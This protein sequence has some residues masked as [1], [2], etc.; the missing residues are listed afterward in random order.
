MK[1]L[2]YI[3]S[4]FI[5][6]ILSIGLVGCGSKTPTTVVENYLDEV[7]KGEDG[8]ASHL[9]KTV[10]EDFE[11][12][13]SDDVEE[14]LSSEFNDELNKIMKK[15]EY[16]VNSETVDGDTAIVNVTV[17]GGNISNALVQAITSA[18]GRT[19]ELAFSGNEISDEESEKIINEEFLNALKN[20]EFDERTCDISLVKEDKEW[21][22]EEDDSLKIL[23]LGEGDIE[24]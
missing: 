9:L 5:I 10:L 14:E 1:K 19:F 12:E 20:I 2:K 4:L 15:L 13:N 21:K 8:D 16:K 6:V 11:E 17:N 22:I 7:K 18:M 23:V 24:E 3:L